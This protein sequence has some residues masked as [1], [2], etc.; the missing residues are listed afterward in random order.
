MAEQIF[1]QKCNKTMG[2][3]NYYT[4]KD[5]SKAELCKACLTMHINNWEPE[6]FLWI[7]KK[8]DVPYVPQ[9]W[10]ILRDRAYA[11]DPYK[12]TG[13]SVIGRYLS[14]MKLKQWKDKT[15]EDGEKIVEEMKLRALDSGNINQVSQQQIEEMREAAERGEISEAQ[16]KTYAATHQPDPPPPDFVSPSSCRQGDANPYSPYPVND[17]PYEEVE[18]VDV[19]NEL[20]QDDKIYLAMKWGRLYSAAEWVDLEQLYN[21]FMESFDIQNAGRSET[22]KMICKTTL[23][24]NQAIDS[25]DI[26][27]YQKLSKVYDSMMKSAKFTEAQN[28][29]QDNSSFSSVGELV[30][31]CEKKEGQIPKFEIDYPLDIVDKVI[32]DLKNYTSNLIKED[33]GLAQQIEQYIKKKEIAEE[34]ERNRQKAINNNE[35]Y[36]EINDKDIEDYYSNIEAQLQQDKLLF[37]GDS[38]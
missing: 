4:Y 1:C 25:G 26:D 28:K 3:V 18:L 19:G 37:E 20:T 15:W 34:Q 13:M 9:E 24:M 22:L 5:G 27:A 31:F 17:H 23:K 2:A 7:L 21:E 11:K 10:N 8:F 38:I 36:V 12:M 16:Y 14:K 33:A 30:D 32:M 29:D 6:T 35:N